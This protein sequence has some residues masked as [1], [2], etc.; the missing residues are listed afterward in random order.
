MSIV[1]M[2]STRVKPARKTGNIRFAPSS[3]RLLLASLSCLALRL[4][5]RKKD[6]FDISV[7]VVSSLLISGRPR[8]ADL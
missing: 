8:E 7:P 6:T 2:S 1:T 5:P 3:A 4:K